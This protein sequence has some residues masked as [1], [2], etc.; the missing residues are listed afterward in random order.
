MLARSVLAM[1]SLCCWGHGPKVTFLHVFTEQVLG[2]LEKEA[3]GHPWSLL[4]FYLIT[5]SSLW[6]RCP[7]VGI[8]NIGTHIFIDCVQSEISIHI[9][10]HDFL[11]TSILIP[12]LLSLRSSSQPVNNCQWINV[13][14]YFWPSLIV[15]K[16][17]NK[18][19]VKHLLEPGTRDSDW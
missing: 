16:M 5:K 7:L 15:D 9:C 2:W 19:S 13:E 4:F 6:G 17:D 12:F 3:D 14:L 11:V 10:F 1:V 18:M 8:Y